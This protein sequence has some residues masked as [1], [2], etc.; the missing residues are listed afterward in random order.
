[1]TEAQLEETE[2]GLYPTGDGWFVVSARDARWTGGQPFGAQC[3]FEGPWPDASFRQV[4]IKLCVL[5]PGQPNCVYHRELQ[6]EDFLVLSGECLLIVEGE[7]RPV[8]AWDFVHCPPETAHVFI[9]AGEGPCVIL[10][11]GARLE[12]EGL[13]FP[14]SEIARRHGASAEQDTGSGDEAYAHGF[15]GRAPGRPDSWDEL[16]WS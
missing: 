3:T 5:E 6:Q 10:M 4:G 15:P 7:E 9:G 1:M 14:V 12:D 2:S 8:R 11:V 16:P 13:Y